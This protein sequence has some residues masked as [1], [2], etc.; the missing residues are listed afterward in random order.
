MYSLSLQD[1]IE[2]EVQT[3]LSLK[4]QYKELTGEDLAGGGGRK[5]K[6][7]KKANKENKP[8]PQKKEEKKVIEKEDAS[9]EI[10]KQTR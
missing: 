10:K 6:K 4:S 2:K 3:L 1:E 7:D 9:K 8:Q 5:D